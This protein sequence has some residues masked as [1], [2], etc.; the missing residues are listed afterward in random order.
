[1]IALA[2][3]EIVAADEESII[4]NGSLKVAKA[5]SAPLVQDDDRDEANSFVSE[6][7]LL[8]LSLS[9]VLDASRFPRILHRGRPIV[10]QP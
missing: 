6:I 4:L 5:H 3:I 1:V 2:L 9:L 10:P 8:S 7:T